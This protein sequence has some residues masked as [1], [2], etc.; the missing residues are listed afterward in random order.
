MSGLGY[1]K[2]KLFESLNDLVKDGAIDQRLTNA[3][4]CL[5]NVQDQDVPEEYRAR[6]VEIKRKLTQTPLSSERGYVP[7]PISTDDANEL[8]RDILSLFVEVMGGL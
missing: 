1:L 5:L 2:Q 7:R 6:F 8:A 3:A 4:T